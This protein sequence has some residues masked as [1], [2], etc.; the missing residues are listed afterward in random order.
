MFSHALVVIYRV[1]KEYI[2]ET[3]ITLFER[4]IKARMLSPSEAENIPF[5]DFFEVLVN[6]SSTVGARGH[7]KLLQ[8]VKNWISQRYLV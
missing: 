8:S 3:A 4:L 5:A 1:D 2:L 6:I 7:L